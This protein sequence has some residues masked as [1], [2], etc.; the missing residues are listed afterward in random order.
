MKLFGNFRAFLDSTPIHNFRGQNNKALL[1]YLALN[2]DKAHSREKLASLFWETNPKNAR[3]NL[4]NAL[5]ELKN[6]IDK[7][8]K[9]APFLLSSPKTIQFNLRS[10]F[11]I[12]AINFSKA[13]E[14][15]NL[16]AIF[17]LYVG[18]FLEEFPHQTNQFDEWA[19]STRRSFSEKALSLLSDLTQS[20]IENRQ[21][22]K[23][24]EICNRCLLLEP[25]NEHAHQHL[26]QIYGIRG[27]K[28]LV[29]KQ[30]EQFRSILQQEFESEP[31]A[32]TTAIFRH[33]YLGSHSGH[34]PLL[35]NDFN[36]IKLPENQIPD[37]AFLPQPSIMPLWKNPLFVGRQA[38]LLTLAKALNSNQALTINQT[39]AATGLG[40]IG[41]TQLASEFVHR[42]GQ[43][44]PGGVFWLSF[45]EPEAIPAEV[46]ACGDAGA[47]NL[48]PNF[49]NLPLQDQ[50]KRVQAAWNEPIPRLLI[51]DN[52]EDPALLSLWRPKTGGCRIL[53][54]S[55]RGDWSSSLGV[56]T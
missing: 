2:A 8:N 47:L 13:Q 18:E 6:L 34:S 22:K 5:Y 46:A 45:D 50:V 39:A 37:V 31:S 38:D 53:I 55:R 7:Q 43:F 27:K 52:C 49:L 15:S 4:R 21:L 3:K 19:R 12:D 1:V 28:Y 33:L 20:C 32:D 54:T 24:E 40:G 14:E 35:I 11:E 51:F 36:E 44:F 10:N 26:M 29:A 25:W 9:D 23:A 48:A 56:G 16:D 17:H 41:K 30:Y 42:Y